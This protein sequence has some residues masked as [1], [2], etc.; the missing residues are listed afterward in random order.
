MY[1]R[2]AAKL[3]GSELWRFSEVTQIYTSETIVCAVCTKEHGI[4]VLMYLLLYTYSFCCFS[5]S[6]D[7]HRI[8]LKMN[9][10]SDELGNRP[11]YFG[12]PFVQ[13]DWPL[14]VLGDKCCRHHIVV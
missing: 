14:C 4:E 1:I 7:L 11:Y 10:H 8:V 12:C 13:T 5:C 2:D 3:A 9:S 6:G